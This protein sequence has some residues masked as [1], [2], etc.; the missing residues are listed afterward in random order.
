MKIKCKICGNVCG[1]LWSR[2]A[3]EEYVRG[4]F[5]IKCKYCGNENYYKKSK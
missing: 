1:D 3:I 5:C 4:N 2:A